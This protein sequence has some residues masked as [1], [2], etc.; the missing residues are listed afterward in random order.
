MCL[1]FDGQT[2]TQLFIFAHPKP[3]PLDLADIL[4]AYIV[5]DNGYINEP[6]LNLKTLFEV[7][8]QIVSFQAHYVLFEH[9]VWSVDAS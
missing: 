4:V 3:F 5:I 9:T 1:M 7:K 8:V 2:K 6:K